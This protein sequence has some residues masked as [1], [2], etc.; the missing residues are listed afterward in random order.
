VPAPRIRPFDAADA[1]RLAEILDLNG[2]YAYPEVEGPVAMRRVAACDAAIFLVAERD[3]EVLGFVRAVYDG[4]R[5]LIH[6]LSVHPDTA[7][8]GIGSALVAAVEAE[9]ARR[10][11]PGAMVPVTADSAAFWAR[12]GY[13]ELPVHVMLKPRFSG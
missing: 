3:G 7:R 4:A 9:L 12:Q 6:L 8:Q 13:G 2:Q 10:G 11:A 1:P 5:A